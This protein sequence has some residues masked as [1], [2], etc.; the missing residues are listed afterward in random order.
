M[1]RLTLIVLLACSCPAWAAWSKV[2]DQV[3]SGA[4]TAATTA[5]SSPLTNG[6]III[7]GVQ[8]NNN[9]AMGTP[10]DTAA[11][12][13]VSCGTANP[14]LFNTSAAGIACFY[15]LN[16]HT[17][18]SNVV[19]TTC[20]GAGFCRI[21]AMEFTGNAASSPVDVFLA[22]ANQT[23]VGTTGQNVTSGANTT[24][25]NGDLIFGLGAVQTGTLT[26]GTGFTSST[27]T[28]TNQYQVQGSAGSIASTWNDGTATDPYAALMVAFKAPAVAATHG[29]SKRKKLS[30][31]GVIQ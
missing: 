6:S 14:V 16:T 17:T 12:T 7:A 10:T 26:T 24:T 15:S 5:F 8:S 20:S 25:V 18:A 23:T 28:V 31:L 21:N 13:Y 2:N 22:A 1:R 9:T 27:G 30:H 29:L 19:S 3:G 11:N 4:A